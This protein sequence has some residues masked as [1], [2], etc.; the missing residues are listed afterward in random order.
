[1][2]IEINQTVSGFANEFDI[3]IN[4]SRT[5]IGKGSG[6]SSDRSNSLLTFEGSLVLSTKFLN[7]P[8][9]TRFTQ[10]I[11]RAI[12]FVLSLLASWYF[13]SAPIMMLPFTVLLIAFM[14]LSSRGNSRIH[15]VANRSS[16]IVGRM[17]LV[18]TGISSAHYEIDLGNET[19]QACSVNKGRHQHILIF[20]GEDQIA[21]LDYDRHVSKKKHNYV[22]YLL[23]DYQEFNEILSLFAIYYHSYTHG[24]ETAKEMKSGKME[25]HYGPKRQWVWTFE[26]NNKLYDP[27]WVSMHFDGQ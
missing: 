6:Y 12:L 5:F 18:S 20:L 19:L 13:E 7:A 10:I 1:M 8:P 3:S 17:L 22:L 11:A 27:N 14:F 4:G 23:D 25:W 16:D 9:K 15:E 21:Q 26:K 24:A 2:I